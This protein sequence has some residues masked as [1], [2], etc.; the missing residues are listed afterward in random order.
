MSLSDYVIPHRVVPLPGGTTSVKVLGLGLESFVL[1][2]RH[3]APAL[4][5]IYTQAVEGKLDIQEINAIAMTLIDSAPEL[6]ARIIACSIGEPDQWEKA[7]KLP[8]PVQIEI[9]EAA[10]TLTFDVE[11]GIKK[12]METVIRIMESAQEALP[13]PSPTP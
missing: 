5:G 11:G 9:L 7:R 10:G 4:Q 3:H 6:A 2:V 12:V 13:S 8:G 1:L